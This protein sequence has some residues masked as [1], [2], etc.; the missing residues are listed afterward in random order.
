MSTRKPTIDPRSFARNGAAHRQERHIPRVHGTSALDEG[1][2]PTQ[3]ATSE[4]GQ[5]GGRP[6]LFKDE[7]TSRLNLFLPQ[8][9]VKRIR[10]LA[11]EK[12]IS[13]SQL[14]DAWT[15]RMEAI[16]AIQEGMED[17]DKGAVVGHE[18][19]LKRLSKW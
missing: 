6:K 16:E 8:E 13:P 9:T 3:E 10:L 19:A 1:S 17:F 15:R 4:R 18:D 14:V 11:V 12:G 2:G 7:P 5:K